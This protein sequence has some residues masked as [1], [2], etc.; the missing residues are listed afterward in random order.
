MSD[1]K[2]HDR[3]AAGIYRAIALRFYCRFVDMRHSAE[4]C[5]ADLSATHGR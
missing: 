3:H 2:Y 1:P 5:G 4:H